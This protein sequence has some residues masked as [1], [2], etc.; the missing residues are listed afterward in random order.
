[1]GNILQTEQ[2]NRGP[3]SDT[4][5]NTS[6]ST[7]TP[8]ENTNTIVHVDDNP[9][10]IAR[11]ERCKATD[12]LPALIARL[13]LGRER[14]GHGVII[15]SD[16]T[17]FG[18]AYDDWLEMA[19]EEFYDGIVYLTAEELRRERQNSVDN[20]RGCLKIEHIREARKML[21]DAI[22]LLERSK[23]R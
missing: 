21:I 19:H 7:S 20:G 6:M 14:Y 1:M 10:I 5:T 9:E 16:T 22:R 2:E 23:Y 13:A 3:E 12:I 8:N 4:N 18:T 15:D 11:L 17:E